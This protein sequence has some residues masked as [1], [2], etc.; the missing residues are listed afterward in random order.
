M[1]AISEI[2][3]HYI[4]GRRAARKSTL[5]KPTYS[6]PIVFN[7]ILGDIK[8]FARRKGAGNEREWSLVTRAP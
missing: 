5:N 8:A 6:L 2:E 1:E 4:E 7:T 3:T